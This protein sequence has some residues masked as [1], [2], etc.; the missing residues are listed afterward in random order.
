MKKLR[1]QIETLA[2][3]SFSTN[4]EGTLRGTILAHS[5]VSCNSHNDPTC[6]YYDTCGTAG[7]GQETCLPQ[8]K[9]QQIEPLTP[10][11]TNNCY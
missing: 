7:Q 5:D 11:C 10:C 1:L 8:E 4:A 2:V 6:A 9:K 3:E